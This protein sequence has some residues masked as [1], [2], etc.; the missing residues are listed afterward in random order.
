MGS[1]IIGSNT[2][3]SHVIAVALAVAGCGFDTPAPFAGA[4]SSDVAPWHDLGPIVVCDG[5]NRV[6]RPSPAQ[7]GG[8]CG[9]GTRML[10]PC[11]SDGDCR[12]RERCTCGGCQVALCDAAD[13]C[14]PSQVCNF[15][16]R[17]CDRSCASDGDCAA[18]EY[19]A[20]GKCVAAACAKDLDCVDRPTCVVQRIAG[21]LHEPSPISDG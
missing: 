6:G 18:G 16:D 5:A 17:R 14:A 4:R 13:E 1:H 3:G 12:S 10:A 19:C 7:P 21:S 9:D 11:A 8:F 20:G 2:M 15:A